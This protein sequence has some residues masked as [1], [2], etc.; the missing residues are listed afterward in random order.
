M[1]QLLTVFTVPR[2]YYPT[3]IK[4]RIFVDQQKITFNSHEVIVHREEKGF[5][6]YIEVKMSHFPKLKLNINPEIKID[7][8]IQDWCNI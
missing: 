5:L 8:N 6:K 7:C 3:E 1:N 4:M 2:I